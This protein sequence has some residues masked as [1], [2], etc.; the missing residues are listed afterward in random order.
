MITRNNFITAFLSILLLIPLLSLS[1]IDFQ[2]TDGPF[3]LPLL[4]S[5]PESD[6]SRESGIYSEQKTSRV[7][8]SITEIVDELPV[9][10]PDYT[11]KFRNRFTIP[12]SGGNAIVDHNV[13]IFLNKQ[14]YSN[15]IDSAHFIMNITTNGTYPENTPISTDPLHGWIDTSIVIPRLSDLNTI[16]GIQ[17]GDTATIYQWLDPRNTRFLDGV[18]PIYFADNFSVSG[19][20]QISEVVG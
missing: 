3:I 6:T 16:Y 1:S 11:I 10:Y 19:F 14:G 15:P 18:Q 17:P 2:Q 20:S 9:Y 7:D 12:N 5:N 8:P 4:S 13:S